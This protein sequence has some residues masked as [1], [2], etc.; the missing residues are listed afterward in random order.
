MCRANSPSCD[1]LEDVTRL[2]YV[3]E[4]SVVHLLR[5]RYGANLV[6]TTVAPRVTVIM[7]AAQPLNIYNAHV[8]AML[9]GGGRLLSPP[10]IFTCA[11]EVHQSIEI[12]Q[13]PS[14]SCTDACNSRSA[15]N[16]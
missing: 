10:H 5:Q 2:D 7:R 3:N 14:A 8:V 6:H 11:Q 12:N 15:V 1:R 9:K 16:R 4:S 13:L